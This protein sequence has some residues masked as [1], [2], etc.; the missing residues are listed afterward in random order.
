MYVKY[1][2][3]ADGVAMSSGKWTLVGIFNTVWMAKFPKKWV[4]LSVFVRIEAERREAGDHTAKLD[5]VDETGQR[6]A[7]PPELKF[8]L[9][10]AGVV[11][12]TPLVAEFVMEVGNL[13]IPGPGN[14]DFTVRVDGTYLYSIPLYVRQRKT[15]A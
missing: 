2:I 11:E 9:D 14:Y 13:N 10:P 15:R 7:D 3:L 12:G 1:G 5:F 4:R 8:S 6:L